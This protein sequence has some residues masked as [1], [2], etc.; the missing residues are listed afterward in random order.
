MR[1]GYFTLVTLLLGIHVFI[2]VLL[3]VW[4]WKKRHS[5][6]LG[7]LLQIFAFG[8]YFVFI[9]LA[10]TWVLVSFYLRYAL[11]ALF[12]VAAIVS[13]SRIQDRPL[14]AH[15]FPY[16]VK[17]GIGR[18]IGYSSAFLISAI[19]IY[20]IIGALRSYSYEEKPVNLSFPLKGGVYAVFE[21][22]TGKPVLS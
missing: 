13:Y 21:G 19:M 2:P 17:K 9:F 16:R 1:F 5:G 14:G 6:M 20:L 15:G 12:I 22:G 7:W 4:T 3:I 18:W 11:P 8:S 10:G